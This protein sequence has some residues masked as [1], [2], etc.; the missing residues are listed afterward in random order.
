M[1]PSVPQIAK[2]PYVI[3]EAYDLFSNCQAWTREIL[4]PISEIIEVA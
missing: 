3:K 4:D 2:E 1:L